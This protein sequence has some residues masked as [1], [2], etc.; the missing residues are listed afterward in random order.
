MESGLG[1]ITVEENHYWNILCVIV[2][3]CV[4]RGFQPPI[5]KGKHDFTWRDRASSGY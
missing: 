1:E 5:N 4:H 3:W 2:G